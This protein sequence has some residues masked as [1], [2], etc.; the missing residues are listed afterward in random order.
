MVF[1]EYYSVADSM[2]FILANIKTPAMRQI[3]MSTTQIDQSGILIQR[4]P[5][6]DTR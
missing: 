5:G 6:T 3:T 2:R 1:K 4:R